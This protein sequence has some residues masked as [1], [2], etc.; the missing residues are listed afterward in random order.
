MSHV[1]D[2]WIKKFKNKNGHNEELSIILKRPTQLENIRLLHEI[3]FQF[4]NEILFYQMYVQPGENFAKCFYANEQ[5]SI[6]MMI[7]LEN[8]NK[9]GYCPC[10]YRY[11]PPLEYTLAAFREMGQFHGK[12][13]VMKE[14][15]REKF[16]DI[17]K[18]IRKT[19]CDT[20]Y[21]YDI[22]INI[23]APRAVEYLR[24]HGHDVTFCDKMEALLSNAFDEVMMKTIKPL[25]PLS[26][27]CH[28]DFTLSNV[29]F[30]TEN[31]RHD[32]I[33]I[34]FALCTYSTPVVD[35]ST[36][37][38]LCCPN[39]LK[40][41]KFFGIMRVYHDALKNYLLD[42]G[43]SDIE[44]YSYEALL[45]DFRRGA[46]FGFVITSFFL[47]MLRG[48]D[49]ES[50]QTM[51][52]MEYEERGKLLRHYGGDEISKILANTLLHLKDLGC[53]NYF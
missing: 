38:C 20:T 30:K 16:F 44:K 9:R 8:V 37:L 18:R 25:E 22:F 6:D 1:E 17:V 45:D 48:C 26:T 29:L 36:Y 15:Q 32:A 27:L 21:G 11:D 43:I 5:S 51:A 13:Y 34:D 41:D 31:G 24:N 12:G 42:A 49:V 53:L 19:R 52:T 40:G 10:P 47:S 33:L 46:L 3:D 28:G 35:L 4:H 23:I 2:K 39:E 14:L 7:A 50:R